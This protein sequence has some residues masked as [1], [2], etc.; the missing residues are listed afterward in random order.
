M[1]SLL[2]TSHQSI[3]AKQATKVQRTEYGHDPKNSH[4]SPTR[5]SLSQEAEYH[6]LRP[7]ALKHSPKTREQVRHQDNRFRFGLL[8]K[9]SDLY[10]YSE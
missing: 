9:G 7:E 6:T 5:T 4:S 10:L 8:R 1:L 2:T 3:R